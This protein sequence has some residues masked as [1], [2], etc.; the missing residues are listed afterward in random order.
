MVSSSLRTCSTRL[1]PATGLRKTSAWRGGAAEGRVVWHAATR[2]DSGMLILALA[3]QR[4]ISGNAG[5]VP[6][7]RQPTGCDLSLR[8]PPAKE[9]ARYQEGHDRADQRRGISEEIEC[10]T[11]AEGGQPEEYDYQAEEERIFAESVHHSRHGTIDQRIAGTAIKRRSHE[12][13]VT[14]LR[15]DRALT[16]ESASQRGRSAADGDGPAR[17]AHRG[18]CRGVWLRAA[19]D[20]SR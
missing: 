9:P 17:W 10:D 11:Q 7:V 12:P 14:G 1:V 18:L 8:L 5:C 16:H 2:F 15:L 3:F 4:E 6:G 20:R 19:H 13:G